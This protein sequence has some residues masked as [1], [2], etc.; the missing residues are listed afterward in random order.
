MVP[1][2]KTR[3]RVLVLAYYFP[4]M[5]LSGVQRIAKFVKYLPEFGWDPTVITPEPAG[6]F[7][8]DHTLSEELQ[9][10]PQIKVVRTGSLDP[11]RV[12]SRKQGG[13]FSRSLFRKAAGLIN[14]WLFIPDNKIGWVKQAFDAGIDEAQDYPFDA[15]LSSAP[16]YSSHLAGLALKD[17]LRIPLILDFRDDWVGNPRHQYPTRWHLNKHRRLEEKVMQGA[18]QVLTINARIQSL[19]RSRHPEHQK[20]S[21]L[22][23]GYDHADFAGPPVASSTDKLLF[24]Y[25]GVFYD[26]QRPEPFL[27]ALARCAQ[28]EDFAQHVQCRF[29]GIEPEGARKLSRS[30]GIQ[31]LV[32]FT[33]YL[34]H[35]EAVSHLKEADV[36]WMTVGSGPGQDTI[37]TSKLFEYLGALKPILGLVPDGAARDL[38]TELEAGYMA[39]PEDVDEIA[40]T[41]K[42]IYKDYQNGSL[43]RCTQEK[44]SQFDRK[45]LAEQLATVLVSV[46]V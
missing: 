24:V 32:A 6:Y 38:I 12:V 16:P 5:G 31:D 17:H 3:K 40:A 1:P 44:A 21:V 41:L 30:L 4:P 18:D 34:P 11:T 27:Q 15:I 13:L 19:L 25:S 26:K 14:R 29:V 9:Q 43:R 45:V 46:N 36:L 2:G 39:M 8:F 35:R 42:T 23:H 22:P 20:I 33:G 28:E 37:S 10:I 7:A